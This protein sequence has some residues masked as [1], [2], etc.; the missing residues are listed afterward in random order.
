MSFSIQILC[1]SRPAT[2][3]SEIQDH[4]RTLVSTFAP[5]TIEC[6]K[7]P[8]AASIETKVLLA[9][10]GDQLAARWPRI[11]YPVV[12]SPE[13]KTRNTTAFSTWI[14]SLRQAGKP[15][16]ITV[17]GAYGLSPEIKKKAKEIVSLS[18]LTMSHHLCITVLLE[19]IYRAFTILTNHPYS[20]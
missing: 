5:V 15:L 6:L 14:G 11:C 18:P 4:Y 13:G 20:K 9:K 16:I 12:L 1:V 3:F 7:P 10:E 17:G 2:I 19:Q 8:S